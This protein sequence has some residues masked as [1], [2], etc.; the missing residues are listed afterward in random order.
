VHDAASLA[1]HRDVAAYAELARK[2]VD[3]GVWVAGR[4]VW[5][6]SAAH[7]ERELEA[8]VERAG[9]AFAAYSAGTTR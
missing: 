7:G 1:R 9:A 5:Y 4:G 8:V 6:T 2:L 3:H